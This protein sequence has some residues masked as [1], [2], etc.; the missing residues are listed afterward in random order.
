MAFKEFTEFEMR[1]SGEEFDKIGI[2]NIFPPAKDKWNTLYVHFSSSSTVRLFYRQAKFLRKYQRII[3]YIPK[4]L[5][6]KFNELQAIAFTLRHSDTRYKTKVQIADTGLILLK[7]KPNEYTWTTV[8]AD[9]QHGGLPQQSEPE[10]P[11]PEQI[12]LRPMS[13]LFS[14]IRNNIN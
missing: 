3:P 12:N 7:R 11:E 8:L 6:T 14:S 9:E 2:E 13:T 5:Y 4:Q 10:A 1:I